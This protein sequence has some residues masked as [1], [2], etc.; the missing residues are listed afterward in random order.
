MVWESSVPVT[1]FNQRLVRV[2][3]FVVSSN[4]NFEKLQRFV[5]REWDASAEVLKLILFVRNCKEV[6]VKF[7]FY[8][9]RITK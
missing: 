2:E 7:N 3:L 1:A 8:G 4:R 9:L 6:D 5:G